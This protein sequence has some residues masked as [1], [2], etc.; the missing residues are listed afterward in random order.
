MP[1]EEV[2]DADILKQLPT[3]SETVSIMSFSRLLSERAT[4]PLGDFEIKYMYHPKV[5]EAVS[6]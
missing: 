2:T 5:L 6:K 4:Q 1:Q 3:K